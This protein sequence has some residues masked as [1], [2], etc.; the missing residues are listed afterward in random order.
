MARCSVARCSGREE[1]VL[2]KQFPGRRISLQSVRNYPASLSLKWRQLR[3][4]VKICIGHYGNY[5]GA[6]VCR[7]VQ[8]GA[9]T[10]YRFVWN[11]PSVLLTLKHAQIYMA[12]LFCDASFPETSLP[13]QLSDWLQVASAISWLMWI[14]GLGFKVLFD[15]I[16]EV[17]FLEETWHPFIHLT[18]VKTE[19]NIH[20]ETKKRMHQK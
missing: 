6:W 9:K 16:M 11:Y 7:H 17:T 10:V 5:S 8:G 3:D 2:W 19:S 14:L 1:A 20:K 15:W 18:A 4:R 12:L 13:E